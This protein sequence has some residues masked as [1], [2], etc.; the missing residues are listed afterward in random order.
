MD[1][2]IKAGERVEFRKTIGETEISLF[3][4]ITGDFAPVHVDADFASRN[5]FGKR[6]AHGVLVLGLLS[7]T[8][9]VISARSAERGCK[10]VCVSLG[11]DRI[12]FLKPV[13]LGDTITAR[14]TV[15][16]V[17]PVKSRTRSKIEAFNQTGELCLVGE[18]ILKWVEPA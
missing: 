6:I 14:Y 12:R 15:E 3:A 16:E 9:S 7:T 5:P 4:G 17:D 13:L 8:S 10:G 18:H 11:Y 1:P 2:L